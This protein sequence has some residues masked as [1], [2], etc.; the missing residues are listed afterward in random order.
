MDQDLTP[1][2]SPDQSFAG[3]SNAKLP[4]PGESSP[5]ASEQDKA[6]RW[7]GKHFINVRLSI[8]LIFSRIYITLVVGKERRSKTR[9]RAERAKHPL[10][11]LGNVFFF[12]TTS[13]LI[14]ISCFAALIF[15]TVFIILRLFSVDIIL[16]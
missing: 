11:T 12:S 9:R 13:A 7:D 4:Q 8:P 2:E 16:R 10:A 1:V 14:S 15:A 5:S 6:G 3:S